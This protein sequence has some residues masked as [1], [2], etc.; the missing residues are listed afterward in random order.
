MGTRLLLFAPQLLK[1]S[2]S[3]CQQYQ[4]DMETGEQK[5]RCNGLLPILRPKQVP[6]PCKDCPKVGPEHEADHLLTAKNL[7]TL[8]LY[9]EVQATCGACLSERERQDPL[10]LR[11]LSI[12]GGLVR[13]Y[14]AKQQSD[15]MQLAMM[16]ALPTQ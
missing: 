11:N 16:K 12:V 5:T 3:E 1:F 15:R 2:C 13:E 10:L 7:K 4:Y 14:E 8:L 9:R 6:P